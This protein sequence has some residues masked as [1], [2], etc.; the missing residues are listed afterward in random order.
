M[1]NFGLTELRIVDPRCDI[2]S[3]SCVALAAGGIEVL[4]NAK[5][6]DTVENCIFDLER[7]MATTIRP[8]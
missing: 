3:E 5:I 2:K 8:R 1:L 7:V 6:Y 4:E